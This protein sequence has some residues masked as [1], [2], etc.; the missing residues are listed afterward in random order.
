MWLEA[1][2]R[3]VRVVYP[4]IRSIAVH[5][6]LKDTSTLTATGILNGGD[7]VA[8]FEGPVAEVFE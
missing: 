2:P 3:L 8:G 4:G 6:T 5:K 7:M 1:R